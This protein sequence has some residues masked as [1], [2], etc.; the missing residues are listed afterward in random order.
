MIEAPSRVAARVPGRWYETGLAVGLAGAVTVAFVVAYAGVFRTLV[1]QWLSNDTY[2][3]GFLVPWISLYLVWARRDALVRTPLAPSY[4]AGLPVVVAGLA[5]LALGSASGT[6]IVQSLS[7]LVTLAGLVLLMLGWSYLRWLWF[8]IL[9][10]LF[11]VPVW[12][13][14]TG[15]LHMPFQLFSASLG[16]SLLQAVGVS[17]YRQAT[18]IELPNATLEVARV[19]SG[20]NYL[21]A[22]VTIGI[23]AAY[24]FLTGWLRRTALVAFAVI[25]AIL[26]NSLRVAL[27]GVLTYYGIGGDSHGPFHVL[28]GLSVSF[29]GYGAIFAGLRALSARDPS[30][31][32]ARPRAGGVGEQPFA[33]GAATPPRAHAGLAVV[34]LLA[35]A[36]ALHL[37]DVRPAPL[38]RDLGRFPTTIGGWTGRGVEPDYPV[39]RELGVDQELSRAY[40]GDGGRSVRLYIGYF[41]LQSHKREL[42][43]YKADT[44]HEHAVRRRITLQGAGEVAINEAVSRQPGRS[45]LVLFWYDLNGRVAADRYLAK[46]YTALDALLRRRNNGAVVIVTADFAESDGPAAARAQAD[47][48]IREAYPRF[49]EFLESS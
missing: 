3:H 36:G 46:A 1:D 29:L 15:R 9:F 12:E 24:L 16:T 23:P 42:V 8:P 5:M 43:N 31:T 10:L 20:V 4:L 44:L 17:A 27:I 40:A 6:A 47:E 25:V 22:V 33:A 45:R 34:L 49:R 38:M 19:C 41:N 7:L 21:I 48:F 37:R 13:V 32:T 2:S 39:F 18:Y 28:Q 14:L 30:A 26:A 11:M 35:A